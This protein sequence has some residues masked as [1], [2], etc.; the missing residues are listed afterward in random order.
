MLPENLTEF[1]HHSKYLPDLAPDV[2]FLI[3]PN[4]FYGNSN[5]P[6][7]NDL[8]DKVVKLAVPRQTRSGHLVLSAAALGHE[9]E[10]ARY[11]TSIVQA[12]TKHRKQLK[13][14]THY[15][16]M[17]PVLLSRGEV[18][19]TFPWYDTFPE[20]AALLQDLADPKPEGLLYTDMEQGW[21]SAAYATADKIYFLQG[22][23]GGRP[24]T[25]CHTDRARL[26]QAAGLALTRTRQIMEILVKQLGQDYWRFRPPTS[27]W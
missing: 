26:Q 16:W 4:F 13:D 2:A 11:Y 12:A 6:E 8:R 7:P 25:A 18:Q 9:N 23:E 1:T 5:K 24:H 19:L 22:D 3:T 21:T 27:K 20:S 15:F 14:Q 10:L 17:R